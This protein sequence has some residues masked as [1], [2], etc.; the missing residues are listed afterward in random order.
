[1]SGAGRRIIV[2]GVRDGA[3]RQ[4]ARIIGAADHD[5]DAPLGAARELLVEH[6]L[7][8]QRVAHG[9][10]EEVDVEQ[11]EIARDRAHRIEAGADALDD[12]LVAQFLQARASRW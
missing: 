11:I 5:A 1:M 9:D 8:E 10:Q 6:V 4:N 2:H 3:G 12:A 7:F